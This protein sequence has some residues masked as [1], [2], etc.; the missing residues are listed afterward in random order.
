MK[1]AALVAI[2]V[3]GI[4][5]PLAAQ[6]SPGGR[7]PQAR[8]VRVCAAAG[9]YW[10]TMTLALQ[11]G[12]AWVA[13]KQQAKVVRLALAAGRRTATV[14]LDGEVIAVAAGLGSVWALDGGSTLYRIDPKTSRITRRASLG[15]RA[16]YNVW[17]GGGSVWVADDQA[18]QVLRVAPASGKVLR[19]QLREPYWQGHQRRVS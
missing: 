3:T 9:P 7:L 15:A 8:A 10:P 16:A 5:A 1:L 18:A 2:L 4:A 12:V 13:C 19:R 17:I 11:G 6:G 14:G